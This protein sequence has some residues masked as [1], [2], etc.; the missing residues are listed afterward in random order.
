[1][2][3]HKRSKKCKPDPEPDRSIND[4][5]FAEIK[6]A[7]AA[8]SLIQNFELKPKSQKAILS[9]MLEVI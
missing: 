5:F 4:P 9:E 8:K 3:K 6:D 1:M 2:G 7:K